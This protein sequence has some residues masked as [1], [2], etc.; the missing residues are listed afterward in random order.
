MTFTA[1]EVRTY[2]SVRLPKLRQAGREWRGPC[3]VHGGKDDN[4]AVSAETGLAQCHS[5]CKRG[6]DLISLEMELERVAFPKAK[7]R[8]FQ[9]IGRPDIPWDEQD[10]VATYDYT[11][12]TGALLYQVVR[13]YPKKFMQRRP[14]PGGGWIWGIKGLTRVPYRL[15]RVAAAQCVFIVEGEK[16]V[17]TLEGIGLTATC[18]NGGAGNFEAD[19][20]RWFAGKRVAILPDNDDP[21]RDHALKVAALVAPVAGS[22]K[23]VELPGLPAKGD[24]TDFVYA[25]GTVEQLREL[26]KQAQ[27]WT[28]EW[29]YSVA[30]PCED[31][32]YVHTIE[33]EVESAGGLTAFW[34]PLKTS[35]L[36]TPWASLDRSLNGGMRPGEVYVIGA[37]Q[38]SGK[39]SMG[40][41][42]I[43]T[44]LRHKV[45]VLMFSM[46]MTAR[47]V[48]ERMASM[49]ARI[50]LGEYRDRQRTGQDVGPMMDRLA[51]MTV[52]LAQ[53][54][55]LVST[56]PSITPEY[57]VTET[58]RLSKRSPVD[59]VVVDHMQLMSA[60][61]G[62]RS[63][64]E[65][66]TAISRAM[67]QT[68]M[69]IGVPLLVVSQ[70]SRANSKEHRGELE[71]SDLRGSGAIE[72]DAAGVFLLFED[73]DDA[74]VAR[75]GD[76][77]RYIDGPVK[78]WLK[79]AKNRYG[80]QGVHM[81]MQHFK[82]WTRFERDG[83]I[84]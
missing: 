59:L 2:Y 58:R 36:P 72:E 7:A 3:P 75:A 53:F 14:A 34:S 84:A 81:A 1:S 43:V 4:F 71:V 27:Q 21:G 49:E 5:Q 63:E 37:N 10:I 28:P 20:V 13:K 12:E 30:I 15:P 42:F 74:E 80:Q 50:N 8:V 65:K 16:D 40:L 79:V 29:Q 60:E 82:Q 44:A 39:T 9:T 25:G 51:R 6:W 11:D 61:S 83:G 31:D 57:I 41:Q 55:L 17:H 46:E 22:V 19:L 54:S 69:E 18:N 66:F 32:K 33:Q 48:V 56:K 67:K 62:G 64:Y 68:A 77:Q 38:G 73:R 23:I 26:Y 78:T 47:D 70:T 24:V 76:G 52:E 35:G 45:G